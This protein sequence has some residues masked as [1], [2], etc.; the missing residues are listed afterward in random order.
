MILI[1]M[2][3]AVKLSQRERNEG[4]LLGKTEVLFTNAT[5]GAAQRIMSLVYY[6]SNKPSHEAFRARIC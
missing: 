3:E 5:T 2:D 6:S 4:K 1:I